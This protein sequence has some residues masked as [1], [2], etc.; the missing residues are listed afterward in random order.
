[1]SELWN[2]ARADF[3]LTLLM[4]F[5]ALTAAGLVPFAAYRFV[6]GDVWHGILDS[7]VVAV[8]ALG[9]LRALKTGKTEGIALVIAVLYSASCLL[10]AQAGGL[11][12]VFWA[13]PVVLANFLLTRR[14]HAAC[15]S[16]AAIALIV[17]S[18]ALPSMLHKAMFVVTTVEVGLF[19]YV[20][21]WRAESQR[22]QLEADA[23]QDPL[24][25]ANNRR[26][27]GAVLRAA[28]AD[29]VRDGTPLGLLVFDI[30]RFKSINDSLGH[31]AGDR[32][33]VRVAELV[34]HCTR[35][36]DR[37]FRLGGE[38]FGLLVPGADAHALHGIA[39]KLRTTIAAEVRVDDRAVT[40][41]VGATNFR[42]GESAGSMQRRADLAMYRA[43]REGRNRTVLDDGSEESASPAS[44]S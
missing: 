44:Q 37:F 4:S 36:E 9:A 11:S 23:A 35:K 2:K 22:A 1:M 12:G 39:E 19:A 18:Q 28:M 41:S 3:R 27:M 13:Y 40:M 21:A 33:L 42:P 43:K 16:I 29:S 6:V 32:V 17:F 15:L 14:R 31:A 26:N 5:A 10:S 8:V 34:R 25:G 7:V 30:D 38:E 20:F 24:T